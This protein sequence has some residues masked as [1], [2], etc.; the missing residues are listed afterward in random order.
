M[1]CH[2][3][4]RFLRTF[5]VNGNDVS[6]YCVLLLLR[7][8]FAGHIFDCVCWLAAADGELS[9]STRTRPLAEMNVCRQCPVF[10]RACCTG[11]I[12]QSTATA[13][14]NRAQI[15]S[16]CDPTSS[17][18]NRDDRGGAAA[19]SNETGLSDRECC[20]PPSEAKQ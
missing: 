20:R 3:R 9:L 1:R 6:C 19:V 18:R 2:L 11:F 12:R 8:A 7:R 15:A 14:A 13:T 5:C 17:A 10:W 16:C 4:G